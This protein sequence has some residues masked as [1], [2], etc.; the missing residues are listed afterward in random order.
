[1]KR[2][3]RACCAPPLTDELL[4]DYTQRLLSSTDDEVLG[5][6]DKVIAL[7]TAWWNAPFSDG[8]EGRVYERHD[9]YDLSGPALEAIKTHRLRKY[10]LEA[11]GRVFDRLSDVPMRNAAFHLLWFCIELS[12]DC[13]PITTDRLA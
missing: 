3:N 9:V 12:A 10:E 8:F 4:A 7:A 1:M 5:A 6:A 2:R 11:I 13:E